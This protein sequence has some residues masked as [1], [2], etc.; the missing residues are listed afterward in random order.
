MIARGSLYETITLIEIF[1]MRSWISPD[2]FQQLETKANDIAIKINA[3]YN[4][5][6][7]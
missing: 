3:L 4:S 7:Q 5:I 2:K 6:K 1:K